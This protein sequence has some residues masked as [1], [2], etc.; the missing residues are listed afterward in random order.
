MVRAW[1]QH[2]D[3]TTSAFTMNGP[4]TA[5]LDYL[6]AHD[7]VSEVGRIAL[8]LHISL[9]SAEEAVVSLASMGLIDFEY[10]GTHFEIRIANN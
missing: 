6:A 7:A 8:D 9:Q 10:T 5:I 2:N 3:G 1:Q 4:H